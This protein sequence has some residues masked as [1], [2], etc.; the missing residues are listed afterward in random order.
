MGR[1]DAR[2]SRP[3]LF[4]GDGTIT[5]A[6]SVLSAVEGL[7]VAEPSLESFVVPIA[8]VVLSLLFALQRYG[9][10]AV[11]RLFGPVMGLWFAV[12]AVSGLKQVSEH[13]CHPASNAAAIGR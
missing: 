8:L 12:L 6:I 9:T 2:D 10:G 1:R 4:Y 5:P 13:P 7:K 3:S 11:G